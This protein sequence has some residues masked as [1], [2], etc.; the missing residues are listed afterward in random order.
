MS[1]RLLAALLTAASLVLAACG[2]DDDGGGTGEEA[3]ASSPTTEG[4]TATTAAGP[5]ATVPASACEL[6]PA[7]AVNEATGLTLGPGAEIGDERRAV[8]AFSATESGGVGVTVGVEAGGRFDEKAESS[9]NALGDEGDPVDGLGEEA[10]FFYDDEDTP[11]GLGGVLVGI[12][13]VTV[14]VTV[15][16]TGDEDATREASV[17]IAEMAVENL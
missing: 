7:D 17:A 1:H 14:D 10:L 3:A 5:A 11:E 9:Q 8:C 4:T 15:Q 13:D 6:V 16:G 12:G 2:G